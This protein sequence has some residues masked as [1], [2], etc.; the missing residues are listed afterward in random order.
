VTRDTSTGQVLE[1]MILHSLVQGGYSYEI[2]VDIGKRPGGSKHKVDALAAKGNDI[3]LVSLKW[4]QVTGTA[5]Q[6]VPFEVI[7]LMEAVRST[8]AFRKAYLVLGGPGWKL[9]EFYVSGG[10]KEYLRYSELVEIMTLEVFL[11]LAN[12]GSL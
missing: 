6:K 4:Q 7:C 8:A 3:F 2:Q 5:E 12:S 10:L 1:Q 9:R 11:A